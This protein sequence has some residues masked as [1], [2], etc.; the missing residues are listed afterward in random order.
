MKYQSENHR[1]CVTGQSPVDLH[2]LKTRAA[3][4]G[5]EDWNL[6]P[7]IHS[8]HVEIHQIGLKRFIEKYPEARAWLIAHDW[9]FDLLFCKWSHR[10]L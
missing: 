3:G 10:D 1:C 7:L 5:D 6:M 9:D 8:L 2:H 4:G